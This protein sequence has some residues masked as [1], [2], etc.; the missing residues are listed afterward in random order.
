MSADALRSASGAIKRLLTGRIPNANVF[1]GALDDEDARQADLVLFLYR[2]GVDADLRNV[3]HDLPPN[4]LTA[5]STPTE[6]ALP[7]QLHFL[8]T[9]GNR[10]TGSE[11]EALG[12][13]GLAIQTLNDTPVLTG[14]S[15]G[16][17]PVR[18]TFD[19]VSSEELSRIWSLFPTAN[20]RTSVSYLVSPVWVDPA[21]E[22]PLA[23]PVVHERY[24]ARSV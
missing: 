10:N 9:A 18:I 4:D 1:V 17:D 14:A 12:K 7:L 23:P 5:P 15:L 20:F 24:H 22:R 16:P 21:E 13:L 2:L 11:L 8:L 3:G 19:P 6:G